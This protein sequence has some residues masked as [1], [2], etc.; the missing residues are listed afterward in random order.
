MEGLMTPPGPSG[1]AG[2]GEAVVPRADK[3]LS[4]PYVVPRTDLERDLVRLWSARLK[5]EPI[6]TEDDFFELGGHS[7]MAAELLVDLQQELGVEV[8]ARTLFLQ[9]TVAE[10]AAV[11]AA[12][13]PEEGGA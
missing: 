10:L 13:G 3:E 8:T 7:L 9:P 6:G 5:V 11:I 2:T 4:T 1:G 12:G